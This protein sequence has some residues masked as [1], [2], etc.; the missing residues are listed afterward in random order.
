MLFTGSDSKLY[1]IE[2]LFLELCSNSRTQAEGEIV[3]S[4]LQDDYNT[5]L[6]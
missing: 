3:S 5:G 4:R 2:V 6:K 1:L